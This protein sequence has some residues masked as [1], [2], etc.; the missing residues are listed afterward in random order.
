MALPVFTYVIRDP[1]GRRDVWA[2]PTE[3]DPAPNGRWAVCLIHTSGGVVAADLEFFGPDGLTLD[4]RGSLRPGPVV[5]LW[6]H[7]GTDGEAA[8]T[9]AHE[10]FDIRIGD[11]VLFNA[12]AMHVVDRGGL[13]P[14]FVPATLATAHE[15]CPSCANFLGKALDIAREG[16][17]VAAEGGQGECWGSFTRD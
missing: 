4:A 11:V 12:Q 16:D 10:V 14:E 6:T 9:N 8:A 13:L 7:K 15:D 17:C 1:Y 2:T 5:K 3:A